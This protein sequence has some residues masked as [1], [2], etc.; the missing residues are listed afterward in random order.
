MVSVIG[1]KESLPENDMAV[2]TVGEARKFIVSR[3][4][5]LRDLKFLKSSWDQ[6]SG[7]IYG[8]K[9]IPVERCQNGCKPMISVI[10]GRQAS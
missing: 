5:S 3:L 6:E 1:L 9:V 4:P 7:S 2:T 8:Q 10:K